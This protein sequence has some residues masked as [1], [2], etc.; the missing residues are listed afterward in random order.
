MR[1]ASSARE[2]SLECLSY[3]HAK[4]AIRGACPQRPWPLCPEVVF[5]PP[6]PPIWRIHP[7]RLEVSNASQRRL[8]CPTMRSYWARDLDLHVF[9]T[10]DSTCRSISRVMRNRDH[11]P[12]GRGG[13]R[14]PDL[15]YPVIDRTRSASG[16]T[17]FVLPACGPEPR[18]S[19]PAHGAANMPWQMLRCLLPHGYRARTAGRPA[20]PSRCPA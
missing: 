19:S 2:A 10:T 11:S 16:Q 7:Y 13:R 12:P 17:H 8:R 18:R 4:T 3:L 6:H 20:R 14:R 5:L 1:H 9:S 15:R